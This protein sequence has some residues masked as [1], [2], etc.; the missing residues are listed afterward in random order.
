MTAI[1]LQ[2]IRLCLEFTHSSLLQMYLA[3]NLFINT[4][5]DTLAIKEKHTA[6]QWLSEAQGATWEVNS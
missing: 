5:L 3:S 1:S 2:R 4:F 6:I